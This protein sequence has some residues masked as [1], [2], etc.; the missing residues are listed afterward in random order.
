MTRRMSCSTRMMVTPRSRMRVITSSSSSVSCGFM[1]AAGS[2]SSRSRGLRGQRARHLQLALIA[3]GQIGCLGIA[4]VGEPEELEQLHRVRPHA[5]LL[6]GLAERAL[7]DGAAERLPDR[8]IGAAVLADHHGLQH[9]Q[10][11]E[12]PDVLKGARDPLDRALARDA[13]RPSPVP[14]TRSSRHRRA[15]TPVTRLKNVVLPAPLG[16][17]NAWMWPVLHV[18]VEVVQGKEA[19]EALGQ[20]FDLE[21]IAMAAVSRMTGLPAHGREGDAANRA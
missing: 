2:S 9:R 18:H 13:D 19:A 4:L 3:V 11:R 7:Q 6:P 8:R 16:P 21:A 14:R 12:Q 15:S 10:V 17:I 5:A 1:P 20:A